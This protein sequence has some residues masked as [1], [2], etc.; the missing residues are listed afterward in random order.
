MDARPAF[1]ALL[2]AAL[3]CSCSQST[4]PQHTPRAP[5]PGAFTHEQLIADTRQL[6]DILESAHPDP[7]FAG[8]GRIAFHRRLHRVLNGIP[9]DGMSRDEFFRLLRP[10]VA[11]AGDAHTNLMGYARGSSHPGG[12]PLRFT[13]VEESLVVSGT[14][15]AQKELLG[16]R[17]VAVEGVPLVEL[18]AR[19]KQLRGIDNQYHALQV[20]AQESLLYG[21]DLHDL[22]PEWKEAGRVQVELTQ[23]NG[24][25]IAVDLTQPTTYAAWIRP[26]S[27]VDLPVPDDSGFLYTFL[28]PPSVAKEVAYLRFTHMSGYRETRE[29]RNPLRTNLTR[30]PAATDAFRSLVV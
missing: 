24:D 18:L 1:I 29:G 4:Q 30:P 19:Q 28:K 7:Y 8:G 23:T 16:T 25:I 9:E 26:K 10:F 17:L 27:R 12:I 5:K 20:L 22:V 21:A 2:L 3:A 15:P 14:Q 11:G 6:A 13:V